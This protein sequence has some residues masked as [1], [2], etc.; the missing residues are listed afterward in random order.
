M[1]APACCLWERRRQ[2][3]LQAAA[4]PRRRERTCTRGRGRG[5]GCR[6]GCPRAPRQHRSRGRRDEAHGACGSPRSGC[7]S[8]RCPLR[9]VSVR[10]PWRL[11][12][13][14]ARRSIA[15]PEPRP[16]LLLELHQPELHRRPLGAAT[17]HFEGRSRA[18]GIH[19]LLQ[20]ASA[21]RAAGVLLEPWADA[22]AVK[23]GGATASSAR[24]FHSCDFD[25][26]ATYG[27]VHI[28]RHHSSGHEQLSY[29]FFLDPPL[30][31][32]SF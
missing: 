1:A 21:E 19:E 27:A 14:C 11:G 24:Q 28:S 12:G 5:R 23:V 20:V 26:L 32:R 10:A 31:A 3:R 7:P 25:R 18:Q 6:R 8:R 2:Q 29:R 9:P 16:G 15:A 22:R 30:C 17:L 4:P 13:A